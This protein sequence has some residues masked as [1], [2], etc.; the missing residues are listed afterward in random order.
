MQILDPTIHLALCAV[1]LVA[2]FS[3][4]PLIDMFP[5]FGFGLRSSGWERRSLR[6]FE[7]YE[8]GQNL[9][10][11]ISLSMCSTEMAR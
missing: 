6:R 3:L 9:S 11:L 4:L 7:R 10:S 8:I 2:G 5:A 1:D